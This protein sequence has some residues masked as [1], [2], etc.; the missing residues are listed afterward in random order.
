[1]VWYLCKSVKLVYQSKGVGQP[2]GYD[3]IVCCNGIAVLDVEATSKRISELIDKSGLTNSDLSKKLNVTVQAVH[4]WRHG[5]SLPDAG[6]LF[7]LKQLLG[8]KM[9]DF[10]V[11]G[12]PKEKEG[13]EIHI[14]VVKFSDIKRNDNI[15]SFVNMIQ[16]MRFN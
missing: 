13:F 14:E 3:Y 5:G 2:M 16:K 6:N 4:K 10:F 1:M 9:D 15:M 8:V 12:K 7:A 11:A